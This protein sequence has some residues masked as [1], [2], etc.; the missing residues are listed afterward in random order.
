MS[1]PFCASAETC[2]QRGR[3]ASWN[4]KAIYI[5]AV[6]E[7]SVQH[8]QACGEAIGRWNEAV[9]ARFLMVPDQG[10]DTIVF[11]ERKPTEAPFTEY[12]AAGGLAYNYGDNRTEIYIRQDQPLL[13]HYEWVNLY[14]HEIGHAFGLADHSNDD[15]NSV[16]SYQVSGRWLLGP[17][18]ED[19]K[20]V[21][22]IYGLP[23]LKVTPAMLDGIENVTGFWHWDRYGAGGWRWWFNHLGQNT[24]TELVSYETYTVR[25]EAEGTL[26]NGR[27][28]LNVGPG[29]NRWAYL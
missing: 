16:M 14:A 18:G 26:G 9:G 10:T 11:R 1:H 22:G 19:A 8:P 24:I 23:E 12:S 13:K 20:S 21:A 2:A 27:S 3:W 15:I 28:S 7:P 6:I 17:S 5:K 25:A 29:L 4:G